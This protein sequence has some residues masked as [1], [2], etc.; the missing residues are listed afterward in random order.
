MQVGM[1]KQYMNEERKLYAIRWIMGM[2]IL[3]AFIL[4]VLNYGFYLSSQNQAHIEDGFLFLG[5][6]YLSGSIT[7]LIIRSDR[8]IY[9]RENIVKYLLGL[10]IF[11]EILLFY[12]FY[13]SLNEVWLFRWL[14]L[15]TWKVHIVLFQ[16]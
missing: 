5:F 4:L 7:Q 2:A 1:W 12:V 13:G 6:L 14:D 15:L 3:I 16:L 11:V 10:L 8:W 9:F